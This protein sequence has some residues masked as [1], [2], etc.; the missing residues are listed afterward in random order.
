VYIYSTKQR[1]LLQVSADVRVHN[2]LI[3]MKQYN[4]LKSRLSQKM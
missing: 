4:Y 3:K 1:D 2:F